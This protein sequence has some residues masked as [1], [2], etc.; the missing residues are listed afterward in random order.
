MVRADGIQNLVLSARSNR[1]ELT[2]E[3]MAVENKVPDLDLGLKREMRFI[4]YEMLD[5]DKCFES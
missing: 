1:G 5:F 4:T 3:I 2:H